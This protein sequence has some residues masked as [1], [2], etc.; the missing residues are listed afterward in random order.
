[1][2]PFETYQ[3]RVWSWL[4]AAFSANKPWILTSRTERNH[5]FLEEA[6]EVVQANGMTYI[7]AQ[8]VLGYAFGRPVGEIKQEVGGAMNTLAA[9]CQE[10]GISMTE[11]AETELM[12]CWRDIDKIR[13]KQATKPA[14][15]ETEQ[16]D[17]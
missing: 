11:C 8:Q 4:Q 14:H 13:A 16:V 10:R 1:M 7:Q 9:L 5:R 6:C 15:D 17:G 12:R 3:I 2:P